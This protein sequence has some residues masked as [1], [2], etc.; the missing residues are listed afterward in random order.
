M[1]VPLYE[2][3][4]TRFSALNEYDLR[5][6]VN[7]L[8][9]AAREEEK[10]LGS[11]TSRNVRLLVKLLVDPG[12]ALTQAAVIGAEETVADFVA[13]YGAVRLLLPSEARFLS[14]ALATAAIVSSLSAKA[15]LTPEVLNA[16]LTYRADAVIYGELLEFAT[17]EKFI[18]EIVPDAPD[19]SWI[20]RAFLH[21]AATRCRR[22]GGKQNIDRAREILSRARDV[23]REMPTAQGPE[24]VR[25]ERVLSS[26]LYDLA[27]IDYL[28]GRPSAAREGFHASAEAAERAHNTS[29]YYIS[30]IVEYLVGFYNGVV[31]ADEFRM[32][33][34]E[35]LVYFSRAAEESPHAERWV[36]NAHAH[37][38]D[39]AFLTGDITRADAEFAYLQRDPWVLK[40]HQFEMVNSWRARYHLA[41]HDWHQASTFYE[42]ILEEELSQPDENLVREGIARDLLDYGAALA[43]QG[44]IELARQVWDR[45]LR[46]SDLQVPGP[47]SP[48]LPFDLLKL[49]AKLG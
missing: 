8:I 6:I 4:K 18:A 7:H 22:L 16:L 5:Y 35:A 45:G 28:T 31:K 17:D 47:G 20:A 11:G 32:L 37:L 23:D 49:L 48:G 36:M 27:Y 41:H 9:A 40:F 14:R 39:L 43:G 2:R 1:M 21:N 13:G 19:R 34:E 30:R 12:F 24:D 38:F 25:S 15:V 10:Q 3:E 44:S 46:S 29:G 26:I 42:L 33:L